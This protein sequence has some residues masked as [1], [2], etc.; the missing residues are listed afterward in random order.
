MNKKTQ[1]QKVLKLLKEGPVNSFDLT[2]VYSIKQGPARIKDFVREIEADDQASKTYC[3]EHNIEMKSR[4]DRTGT[5]HWY[6]HRKKE[7]VDGEDVWYW[8]RGNGWKQ[9]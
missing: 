4:T 1:Q 2:Y 5:E 6:D 3:S 9:S 8:C 7:V